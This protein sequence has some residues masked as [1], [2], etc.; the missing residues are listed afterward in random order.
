MKSYS[1]QEIKEAIQVLD[2]CSFNTNDIYTV[3]RFLGLPYKGQDLALQ[4]FLVIPD[5]TVLTFHSDPY[6]EA[7]QLLR[8]GFLPDDHFFT[9]KAKS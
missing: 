6:G 3:R 7:A 4:M 5:E 8:E 9:L 1:K 2:L